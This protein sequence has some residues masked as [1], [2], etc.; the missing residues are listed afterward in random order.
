MSWITPKLDWVATDFYNVYD[1][2]RAVSN[3]SYANS[4]LQSHS[5]SPAT[6]LP[7]VLS[8]GVETLATYSLIN[9]LEENITR[10][11]AAFGVALP[12]WTPSVTWYART[13][14][15]Y[16]RNPSYADWVRWESLSSRIKQLYDFVDT[17][18]YQLI[19]G[20]AY[21]GTNRTLQLLS[22]GRY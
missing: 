18:T 17:Y 10:L 21:V 11:Y 19:C 16:T 12:D 22:R 9:A 15:S 3:I 7:V 6:L 8:R 2:S 13:S 4:L 5:I 20:T 1:L 14:G